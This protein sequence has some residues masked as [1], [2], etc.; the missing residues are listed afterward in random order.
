MCTSQLA[1]S[2]PHLEATEL[3]VSTLCDTWIHL[4]YAQRAGERNRALTIV[5][6]RGTG[7]SNQVRE[8][9]LADDGVSLADVYQSG[10]EV[11]MGTMRWQQENADRD[12]QLRLKTDTVKK[13]LDLERAHNEARSRIETAQREL[14]ILQLELDQAGTEEA[15]RLEQDQHRHVEL[16]SQRR[17]DAD[18]PR[19]ITTP[20]TRGRRLGNGHST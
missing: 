20:K 11:F 8:L 2:D 6:S 16:M 18:P 14:A 5:K 19:G 1:G 15:R 7:H 13:R 12:L 4:A 3:H 10:G 17:A 9:L